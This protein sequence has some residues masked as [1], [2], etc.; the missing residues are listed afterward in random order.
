MNGTVAVLA[1]ITRTH[2]MWHLRPSRPVVS[3]KDS[4]LTVACGRT[5]SALCTRD[6]ML[7]CCGSNERGQLGV[8]ERC[9]RL[10]A[11]RCILFFGPVEGEAGGAFTAVACGDAHTLA[12]SADGGVSGWGVAEDGRLGAL[13]LVPNP[14]CGAQ[15][16]LPSPLHPNY[17]LCSRVRVRCGCR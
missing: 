8:G 6:G 7:M 17:L 15:K 5:H 2:L 10:D 13:L 9:D 16:V 14:L 4:V 1:V 11:M 12:I 3:L